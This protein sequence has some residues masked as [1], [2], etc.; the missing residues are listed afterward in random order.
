M[1]STANELLI[2][3]INGITFLDGSCVFKQWESPAEEHK[4]L[5]CEQCDI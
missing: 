3:L 5:T 2:I 4:Y 1:P